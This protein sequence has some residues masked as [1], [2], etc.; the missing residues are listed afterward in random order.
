MIKLTLDSNRAKINLIFIF[1]LLNVWDF[2]VSREL[3]NA[4]AIGAVAFL[5]VALLWFVGGFRATVLATLISIIEFVMLAIFVIQGFEVSGFATTLKSAFWLPY[6][7]MAVLNTYW[8]LMV[9]QKRIHRS[10]S[11]MSSEV[12]KEL[13]ASSS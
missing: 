12:Q 10:V 7:L 11:E 6:L 5:P 4:M 3:F 13:K 2:I 9:Y 1:I 8:G